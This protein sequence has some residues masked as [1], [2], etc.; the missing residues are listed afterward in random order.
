MVGKSDAPLRP[1]V[2][3][4]DESLIFGE[5]PESPPFPVDTI[6]IDTASELEKLMNRV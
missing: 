2:G 5:G 4:I 6:D 1:V 3:K